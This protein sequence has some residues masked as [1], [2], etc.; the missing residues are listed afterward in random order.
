[1]GDTGV[2]GFFLMVEP[3]LAPEVP[4]SEGLIPGGGGGGGGGT[5]AGVM[6]G[7]QAEV[8]TP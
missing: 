7:G 2:T 5:A 6:G 1:M 4:G 8:D 3:F